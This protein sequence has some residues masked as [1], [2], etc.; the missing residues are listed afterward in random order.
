MD[1][2][3]PKDMQLMLA[4]ARRN[5]QILR[6]LDR[7]EEYLLAPR[8]LEELLG[9]LGQTVC[10]VYELAGGT[11]ALNI[12]HERLAAARGAGPAAPP[13]GVLLLGRQDMRLLLSDLER[14][15]LF[16]H[17]P[18]ELVK[19]LFPGLAPASA[20]VL[21][22]WARGAFL[23]S[24]NLADADPRR[25]QPGLAT[26]FL[27]RLGRKVSAALDAALTARESRALER[28]QAV[29][30]MA[31][32]ACH[33]LAQPLCTMELILER[34]RRRL[35]GSPEEAAD[36]ELLA[37]E[38]ERAGGLIERIRQVGDYVTR[39]YA[40]GLSIVDIKLAACAAEGGGDP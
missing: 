2:V 11:L 9:G 12:E 40:E 8:D 4:E 1:H 13:P 16:D 27:E 38:L 10:R 19:T 39:P 3:S 6:R 15:Q 14:P 30:E 21:P 28:R 35:T 31:G 33:E 32:A 36:L 7:V 20:A 23:G 24:L 26:H 29:V 34:L 5:E 37:A 22:L 18:H 17:P 25:F